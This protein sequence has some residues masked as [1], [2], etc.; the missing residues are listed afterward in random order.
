MAAVGRVTWYESPLTARCSNAGYQYYTACYIEPDFD[1]L[2]DCDQGDGGGVA[3]FHVQE[4]TVLN[5]SVH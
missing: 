4:M 3:E 1:D 5:V 2:V